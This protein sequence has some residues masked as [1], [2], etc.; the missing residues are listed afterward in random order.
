M[1]TPLQLKAVFPATRNPGVWCRV[2]DRMAD[3]FDL[4][5]YNRL[6]MFLAQCG[7]ESTSFNVLRERMSYQTVEKLMA[8]FGKHFPTVESALPY[9]LN[10]AGLANYVYANRLGNGDPGSGDGQMYRGGGLIQLTGRAN[11]KAVGDAIGV[12][13]IMRPKQIETEPVAARSAGYFW[14]MHDLNAAADEGDFDYTTKKINGQAM[15]GHVDRKILW[16]KLLKVLNAPSAQAVAEAKRRA[17]PVPVDGMD[18]PG[19]NRNLYRDPP[20]EVAPVAP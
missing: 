1:I 8:V 9:V 18:D 10:P 20:V 5:P 13:L 15:L 17:I 16:E 12:D 14:K 6:A 3:E 19:A 2:F 7:Y 4:R 11:Y